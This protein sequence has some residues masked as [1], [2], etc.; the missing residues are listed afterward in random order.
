MS[1]VFRTGA[2]GALLDEYEKALT[3]LVSVLSNMS[4]T[5]FCEIADT[6]TS[7]PDCKSV[8]TVTNHVVRSG[9]G[10][11]NQ[12]RKEFGIVWEERKDNYGLQT[13]EEAAHWL[14]EMF[15]YTTNSFTNLS[16][17]MFEIP[18][19]HLITTAWG[20]TFDPDQL[21]EHAIVHILRHRRQIEKFLIV[22]A[23]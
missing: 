20:Q 5:Q 18:S 1:K 10:Y 2:I 19:Q 6:K 9:F 15:R 7:D 16:D 3:E 4:N 8:Q 23:D 14:Q 21:M 12:I 13:P 11:A 22:L 17:E